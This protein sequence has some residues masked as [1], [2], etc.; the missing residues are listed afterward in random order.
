ML[1]HVLDGRYF[2]GVLRMSEAEK[3]RDV[4]HQ[5]SEGSAA[6]KYPLKQPVKLWTVLGLIVMFALVVTAW[7]VYLVYAQG[8]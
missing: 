5:E 6:H 3:L 2:G 1:Y 8:S 4:Q 7:V